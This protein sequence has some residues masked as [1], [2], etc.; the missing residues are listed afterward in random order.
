MHVPVFSIVS[1][2]PFSGTRK[3]PAINCE[4]ETASKVPA[5]TIHSDLPVAEEKAMEG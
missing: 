4:A 1:E 3:S 2:W 5:G